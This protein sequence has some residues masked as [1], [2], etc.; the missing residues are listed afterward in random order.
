M[1]KY[2]ITKASDWNY[3]EIKTISSTDFYKMIKDL[4]NEYDCAL[5][6]DFVTHY[7]EVDVKIM[8]YDDY[9]E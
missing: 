9:V 4:Q 1:I 6:V 3:G 5:I 7:D 2:I 8:I